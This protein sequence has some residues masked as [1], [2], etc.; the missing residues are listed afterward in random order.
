MATINLIRLAQITVLVVFLGYLFYKSYL[1]L[2]TNASFEAFTSDPAPTRA[3]D[4]RCLPGYVPSNSKKSGELVLDPRGW[5]YLLEGSKKY[6][7]WWNMHELGFWWW[8]STYRWATSEEVSKYTD[9]GWAS[10]D[11][12]KN[13]LANKGKSVESPFYFCQSLNDTGKTKTCY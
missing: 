12:V 4:C 3:S 9:G 7:Y 8:N 6:G 13:T 11:Q 1:T 5:G 10:K 2:E